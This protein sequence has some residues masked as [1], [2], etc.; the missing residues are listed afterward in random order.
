MS[1]DDR[2]RQALTDRLRE[3]K[4]LFDGMPP[5]GGVEPPYEGWKEADPRYRT[6][7]EIAESIAADIEQRDPFKKGHQYRAMDL[8]RAI[9]EEMNLDSRRIEG[10]RVGSLLHDI[11]K[12]FIPTELLLKPTRLT[13]AENQLLI[14]HV[15]S[16][17]ELLQDIP[18]PWPVARMLL[19]HHERIDGSGYPD[20]LRG[21]SLIL[22]SRI[23]A[24]ADVV[25]AIAS[26][27]S[28][29]PARGIEVALYDIKGF[30][31]IRYDPDV[32]DAC[33]MLFEEKG[34]RLPMDYD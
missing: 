3:I 27:R 18:F 14:T 28:Y 2:I 6:L 7:L 32:V 23:L 25:D 20:G 15:R 1:E 16:G 5:A 12:I 9:G 31:G 29:R 17:I 13:A 24:V 11:G 4:R 19:E 22:E 33:L 30:R 34:Y 26:P 10:L 8:A 21:E